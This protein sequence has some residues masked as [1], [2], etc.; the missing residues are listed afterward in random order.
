[1]SSK[2]RTKRSLLAVTVAMVLAG[3]ADASE[4]RGK[5]AP[6]V[7]ARAEAGAP[8][9]VLIRLRSTPT[10]L[11]T[12]A[13]AGFETGIAAAVAK[14]QADAERG[15]AQLRRELD[16]RGLEYRSFW[17]ANLIVARVTPD[18]L[19]WIG[20]RDDVAAIESDAPRAQRLPRP[21]FGAARAQPKTTGWNVDKVNAPLVWAAGYTGQGVVIAGQDTGYDW[22][23]PA[24][25]TKYRGWNGVSADHD[26]NWR[27]GIQAPVVGGSNCGYAATSPCDD[28]GHGTHTMGTMVGDDGAGNQIGVAPGAKWIGCRNM[29]EGNGRPSTYIDCFEWFMAPRP[30][31]GGA[32]N[33]ALAPHVISNSWG[34]P[35]EEQCTLTSFDQTLANV[36]AAGIVVVV[37]A[38]NDGSGCESIF[39]PPAISADVFTVASSTQ[40]DAMSGFSSRGPIT[41]D[42]SNRLKPDITAPG[43][44][45]RSSFPGTGYGNSSGTSMATPHVAGVVALLMSVDPT[46]KGQP[47]LVE[48]LIRTTAR[49]LVTAQTCGGVPG[50]TIPNPVQGWGLIDAYAAYET[51]AGMIFRDGLEDQ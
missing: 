24:L 16:A 1:M 21:E 3:G 6:E 5:T 43:S 13:K 46:L 47:Q 10:D 2:L 50:T 17:V 30:V 22:D 4:W 44:S 38:G 31:A 35:P 40:S 14:L 37:A 41:V 23:H 26:Y 11:T 8:L 9:D 25:M 34:C 45:I 19:R 42:G 18:D 28:N 20:A 32:G 36:R 12:P 33:P 15:Q 39:T 29:D 7:L 49:P 51:L 27:D 48:D